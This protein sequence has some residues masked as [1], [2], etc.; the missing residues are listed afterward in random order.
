MGLNSWHGNFD[1]V[2]AAY[3]VDYDVMLMTDRKRKTQN[4]QAGIE[5]LKNSNIKIVI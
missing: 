2:V 3:T 1:D 5:S 4:R